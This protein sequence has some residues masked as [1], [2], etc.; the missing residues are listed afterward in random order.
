[1]SGAARGDR[2]RLYGSCSGAGGYPLRVDSDG[3]VVDDLSH[4]DDIV[5]RV[6][7]GFELMWLKAAE[8]REQEVC[9][10]L[11]VDVGK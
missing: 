2:R 8:A 1:M 5:R 9:E 11:G 4:G 6:R 7:E 3:I 10:L